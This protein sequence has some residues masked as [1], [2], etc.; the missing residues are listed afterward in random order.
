MTSIRTGL[1]AIALMFFMLTAQAENSNPD[2]NAA[3]NRH[4]PEITYETL[5]KSID[6]GQVFIIDANSEQSYKNGHIPL[7]HTINDRERLITQLPA[8]KS[9]PIVVYCGG[10]QCTAWHKAAD[11]AAAQ[12]Y[13]NIMH[14]KGG[15]K[16]WKEQGDSLA[17]GSGA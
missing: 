11:L 2:Q 7:A 3:Y 14:F 4:Y 13:T 17:T 6:L 5:R 12:G 10:P 16:G 15:I 1:T 8:L 9:Y